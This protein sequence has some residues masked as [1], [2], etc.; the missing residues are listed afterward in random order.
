MTWVF[1]TWLLI[2]VVFLLAKQTDN[3]L[4][5][6]RIDRECRRLGFDLRRN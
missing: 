2:S 6:R 4:R 3:W 1:A 5:Q